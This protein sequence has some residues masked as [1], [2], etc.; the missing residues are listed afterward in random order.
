M[1]TLGRQLDYIFK[2][3]AAGDICEEFFLINYFELGRPTFNPD[4]WRWEDPP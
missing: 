2:T 3:Q 1:I 4:L